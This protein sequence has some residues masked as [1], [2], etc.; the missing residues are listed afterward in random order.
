LLSRRDG[1]GVHVPVRHLGMSQS[2]T[3]EAVVVAAA[4]GDGYVRRRPAVLL[5]RHGRHHLRRHRGASQR[6]LHHRRE[7]ALQTGRL[8]AIPRQRPIHHGGIGLELPLHHGWTGI[9]HVGP[10]EQTDHAETQS[11]PTALHRL[12]LHPVVVLHVPSVHE[13]EVARIYDELSDGE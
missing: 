4:I 3:E 7:W 8:H 10:D 1:F 9:R 12:C 13:N 11:Y 5:P 2:E 6:R